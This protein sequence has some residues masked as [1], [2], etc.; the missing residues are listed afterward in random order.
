MKSYRF[1][2]I[3]AG[4]RLALEVPKKGDY[5]WGA[6]QRVFEPIQ[7]FEPVVADCV[8]SKFPVL[9][10]AY[11]PANPYGVFPWDLPLPEGYKPDGGWIGERPAIRDCKEGDWVL[12]V[13][14]RIIQTEN[15]RPGLA[16]LHVRRVATPEPGPEERVRIWDE[17]NH[18]WWANDKSCTFK[19]EHAE[20]L[21]WNLKHLGY[22]IRPVEKPKKPKRTRVV[23]EL[24]KAN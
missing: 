20:S 13:D 10:P 6:L 4:C 9:R 24:A 16:L 8:T 15:Y 7:T 18:R 2:S 22:E 21:I 1:D 12:E 5:A 14:G 19:R 17:P 3:P 11:P 23:V